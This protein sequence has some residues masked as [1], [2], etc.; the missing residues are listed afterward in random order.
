MPTKKK[1]LFPPIIFKQTVQTKLLTFHI[2]P[3]QAI[4]KTHHSHSRY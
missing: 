3:K 2:N 4:Y 1:R